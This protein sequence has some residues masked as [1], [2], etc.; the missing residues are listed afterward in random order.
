MRDV[1]N[2]NNMPEKARLDQ[3]CVVTLR[4]WGTEHILDSTKK[5]SDKN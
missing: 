3:E 5:A 1:V 2:R 4:I